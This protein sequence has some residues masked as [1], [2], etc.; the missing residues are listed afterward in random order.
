MDTVTGDVMPEEFGYCDH[1]NSC[2]Y[3]KYPNFGESR[4]FQINQPPP[5]PPQVFIDKDIVMKSMTWYDKNPF[6]RSILEKFGDDAEP[7]LESYFIGTTKKLGT[8][9]WTINSDMVTTSGKVI[10]YI[11]LDSETKL[12]PYRNKETFPYYPYKKEDGYYPCFF[13]QHLVKKDSV[14]WLVESEK[15][16]ILC[17]IKW[18]EYV[19]ISGGGANGVTSAK[20]KSLKDSGFEGIVNIMPDADVAGRGRAG[21]MVSNFDT[22]GFKCIVHDIGEEFVDGEDYGDLILM[23]RKESMQN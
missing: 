14:L 3:F 15:T 6:T 10:T 1:I 20:V 2:R 7:V 16:A 13:G 22:Y 18:P 19:W 8:I 21:K 17:S 4:I 11:G 9:F 5:P 12:A 23:E